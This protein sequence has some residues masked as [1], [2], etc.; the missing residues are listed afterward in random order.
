M[1]I[2][3]L[4]ILALIGSTASAS[5]VYTYNLTLT[6][7]N[8]DQAQLPAEYGG[9]YFYL[10]N[11]NIFPNSSYQSVELTRLTL[12]GVDAGYSLTYDSDGNPMIT[13]I[14][15]GTLEAHQNATL[16]MSFRATLSKAQLNLTSPGNLSSI[17]L[18]LRQA[19]P[20]TGSFNISG[21]T[22]SQEIVETALS[23]KGDEED[24]LA[25]LL[26][27]AKWFEDNMVYS[28]NLSIPQ[29]ISQT[30]AS[31]SGDCDDQANLFVTFCRIIGIP[32]YTTIGPIYLT[33]TTI[34]SE[35][36]LRFNLTNAAWHG[37]VMAYLPG[38]GGQ[39]VPIDLTFF[40][41]AVLIDG[42][43]RSTDLTQHITGS[44]LVYWDTLEYAYIKNM[45]YVSSAVQSKEN[46]TSS[47]IIWVEQHFM[48][49]VS[50]QPSY[51]PGLE[52]SFSILMFIVAIF[53]VLVF[54][55]T[56][57]RRRSRGAGPPPTVSL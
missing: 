30:F 19:Y 27:M 35:E 14:T 22:N 7:I 5:P 9:A 21:I 48:T 44:A 25:I 52:D 43:V 16:L 56:Y 54:V 1:S 28:S 10:L 41:G 37:W 23:I 40:R 36:N 3:P 47:D 2:L 12:N 45:N 26:N 24:V 15:N 6:L 32:A 18:E 13:V 8:G 53:A 29:D 4:L 20:L 31:K 50:Q 38:N 34:E 55:I 33:G 39:W 17:P 57:L 46:I 51:L 11:Q 49:L 42:H